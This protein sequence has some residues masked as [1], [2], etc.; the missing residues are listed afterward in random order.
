MFDNT[1]RVARSAGQPC[2]KNSIAALLKVQSKLCQSYSVLYLRGASNFRVQ[3][4]QHVSISFC[5]DIENVD[6]KQYPHGPWI[7][8]HGIE[9]GR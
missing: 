1:P 3:V 2:Y 7:T 6:A 4:L 9:H 5:T 8:C